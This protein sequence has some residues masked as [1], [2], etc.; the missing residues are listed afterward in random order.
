MS[1]WGAILDRNWVLEGVVIC[2]FGTAVLPLLWTFSGA[3]GW[4][5]CLQIVSGHVWAGFEVLSVL[6]VQRMFPNS[7][8]KALA[9]TLAAGTLGSALGGLAG[10]SLLDW[11]LTISQV[12]RLSTAVR[13]AAVL[14][15]LFYLRSHG[16]FRFRSLHIPQS[17][18]QLL[19]L[20][21]T[22]NAARSIRTTMSSAV[23]AKGLTSGR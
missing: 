7:I 18:L 8:M 19:S 22:K 6:V 17:V 23:G 15:L 4:V 11:G 3:F 1:N 20:E 21:P 14:G 12:F 10:G 13:L 5:V 2:G 16:A 9:V